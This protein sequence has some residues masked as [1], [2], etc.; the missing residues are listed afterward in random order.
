MSEPMRHPGEETL[1]SYADGELPG[2]A[3]RQVRGH[4]EACWQC[5]AELEEIQAVV[6]ECVRYRADVLQAHLPPPPAP[7]ADP[8][9]KFAEIDAR[10]L[11]LGERAAR[12]IAFPA[13]RVR[14]WA[15]VAAA[16]VLGALL[17]HGL[18]E[19]PTVEAAQLLR[20]AVAAED[21]RPRGARR[22]QIRTR[23]QKLTRVV[24]AAAVEP[25]AGGEAASL[26]RLF[27]AANYSW[28]NPLSA[29]AFKRWHDGLAEKRDEVASL[30]DGYRVR[31]VAETGELAAAS[32]TLRAPD[33]RPVETRLEFRNREWVE[34]TELGEAQ[35]P[36]EVAA[37][38]A[39]PPAV[40]P[41]DKR[42]AAPPATL[43]DELR[44]LA[45]LHGVGADLG[46]PVEVTRVG[47][48]VVVS[49]VGVAPARRERIQQ[50]LETVPK[51]ELR[52]SEP[53][54]AEEVE[55]REGAE[56]SVSSGTLNLH[57]RLEKQVGGRAPFER[58]SAQLLDLSDGTM[59]RAYAL[60]RLAQ[61]F[62]REVES[63]LTP[64]EREVL[65]SLAREH[66]TALARQAGEMERLLAPVLVSLGGVADGA[67]GAAAAEAW[68][69][70]TERTFRAARRVERLLAVMLGVAPGETP[71]AEL[72]SQLLDG[73]ARLRAC[74]EAL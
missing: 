33:L 62:P 18:R 50:A 3:A 4:L 28:E 1:L 22:I 34:I 45:A 57:A 13:R 26:E 17:Y 14:R 74:A 15:P 42:E 43:G 73:L 5:R 24:G 6:G 47:G 36:E 21:A 51:V 56:T 66:A 58:L 69:P 35:A 60:R 68:Q 71:G 31:T 10:R 20:K 25:A 64:A 59:S 44:V 23:R 16:L 9:P 65:R 54:A 67:P 19:T 70:A 29:S 63:G 32:L 40:F 11:T 49:G 55:P 72:P 48:R 37:G 53:P 7:W 38:V 46:D 41:A 52:F 39:A 27:R 8:Y 12:V 61:R 2:R 30:E